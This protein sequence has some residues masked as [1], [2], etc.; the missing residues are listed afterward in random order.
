[1]NAVA[2]PIHAWKKQEERHFQKMLAF[3]KPFGVVVS[4]NSFERSGSP[5]GVVT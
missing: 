3:V 1:M 5:T 4:T 2:L